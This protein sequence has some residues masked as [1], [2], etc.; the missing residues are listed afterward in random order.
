MREI[1]IRD[2]HIHTG[3]WV[4][5][6]SEETFIITDRGRQ[7]AVLKPIAMEGSTGIPLPRRDVKKMPIL[8]ED[9]GGIIS[10]DRDRA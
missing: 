8:H 10:D 4:R 7:V 2:L 5:K 9:S 6:A 1:S 3:D